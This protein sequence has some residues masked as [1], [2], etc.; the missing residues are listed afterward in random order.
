MNYEQLGAEIGKLTDKKNKAYGGISRVAEAMKVFFP[1]G[2]PIEK[3]E[4]SLL[5]VRVLDKIN[6]IS[7]GKK[8]AFGENPWKDIAG[9]ALLGVGESREVDDG[10]S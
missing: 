1:N 10:W 3:L 2:I 9:Y 6:R 8:A 7:G 4:D 5:V